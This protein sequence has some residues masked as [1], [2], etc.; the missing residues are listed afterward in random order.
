MYARLCFE[1]PRTGGRLLETGTGEFLKLRH[2]GKLG[3]S[4]LISS[5]LTCGPTYPLFKVP[6]I[7]VFTKYDWLID[8]VDY[9]L[10][11]SGN[12]LSDDAIKELVR[13]RAETKLQEVCI[14][15]LEKF[16]GSDIPH[17]AISSGYRYFDCLVC[18]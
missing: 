4:T 2:E 17:A 9:E 12:G 16:A 6:V 10:G 5:Y 13:E 15:P 18:A 3:N 7:V 1:T 11:P 8:Q 14:K